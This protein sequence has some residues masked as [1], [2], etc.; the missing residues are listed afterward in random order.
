MDFIKKFLRE[1]H[2]RTEDKGFGPLWQPCITAAALGAMKHFNDLDL[3]VDS[4]AVAA[5]NYIW[6]FKSNLKALREGGAALKELD[7]SYLI[8]ETSAYKEAYEKKVPVD[9]WVR[10]YGIPESSFGNQISQGSDAEHGQSV[11]SEDINGGH[12]NDLRAVNVNVNVDHNVVVGPQAVRA[13]PQPGND[14]DNID[15]ESEDILAEVLANLEQ[16]ETGKG[17]KKAKKMGKVRRG[18]SQRKRS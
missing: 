5:K 6:N 11:G 2:P 8:W 1:K 7:E 4:L 12:C 3:P 18:V 14:F 9:E 16:T 17:R 15:T 13:N 10:D